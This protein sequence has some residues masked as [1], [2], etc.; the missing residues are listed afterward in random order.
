MRKIVNI[1]CWLAMA[2]AI[3]SCGPSFEVYD[4]RC[5]GLDEPLGID[6]PDP[7]FSWKI[8]SSQPMDQVAYEI[9]V[10]S[11]LSALKAGKA[12][13]WSSGK[14]VSNEQVMVPYSGTALSSRQLCWWRIRVWKSEKEVCKWSSPQR[15]GIGVIGADALKGEYIGAV[16][17]EL[18]SAI[19]RKDFTLGKLPRTAALHVNSLGYHEVYINGR[20]VSDAVLMP[21]VSQL[22]KRSLITT[23]DVTGLL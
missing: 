5:E 8:S 14:V 2:F 17:G 11:S 12:D 13:L 22:D 9:Q 1:F 19:L 4:L 16:P 15:F 10:A 21:A 18:R 6:S 20:P 23:Y 7:H 3:L